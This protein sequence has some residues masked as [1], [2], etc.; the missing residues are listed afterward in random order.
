MEAY[1]QVGKFD[2]KQ[3]NAEV[4]KLME[5]FKPEKGIAGTNKK[6]IIAKINECRAALQD[7]EV[8]KR[9]RAEKVLDSFYYAVNQHINKKSNAEFNKLKEILTDV[10]PQIQ[11]QSKSTTDQSATR[12]ALQRA[13]LPLVRLAQKDLPPA[14]P[15]L[16]ND[17]AL[18]IQNDLLKSLDN[19]VEAF[20]TIKVL[21][22]REN[23]LNDLFSTNKH[24]R[25]IKANLFRNI[26][27]SKELIKKLHKNEIMDNEQYESLKNNLNEMKNI[28][29][30]PINDEIQN[31]VKII[32]NFIKVEIGEEDTI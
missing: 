17:E 16:S 20:K 7:I 29:S 1:M 32:E 24:N 4:T 8:T 22:E 13:E 5:S 14:P 18:K 3:W 15:A 6:V 26:E 12:K 9:T 11:K 19:A 23:K 2:S 27:S 31:A 25:I 10:F 28:T 30:K 21:V